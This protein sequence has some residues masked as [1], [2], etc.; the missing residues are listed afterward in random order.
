MTRIVAGLLVMLL[1]LGLL[2]GCS[3]MQSTANAQPDD[4]AQ[5]DFSGG[6][7]GGGGGSY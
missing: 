1:S 2:S 7:G 6:G 4:Q 5:W 3:G